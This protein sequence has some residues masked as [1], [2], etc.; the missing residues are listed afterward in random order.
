MIYEAQDY[1][2]ACWLLNDE[3]RHKILETSMDDFE[4]LSLAQQMFKLIREEYL[5]NPKFDI[6][7]IMLSPAGKRY[8]D[9][10]R[11]VT[12]EIPTTQLFP[13]YYERFKK[14]SQQ[15]K[16]K[17]YLAELCLSNSDIDIPEVVQK[18]LEIATGE[19]K[20]NSTGPRE[21]AIEL[22]DMLEE[23]YNL[24]GKLPGI[25]TGYKALD[26]A[27]GGI[28][29]NMYIILGG[30][31]SMGKSAFAINLAFNVL[32]NKGK[33]LYASV[34]MSRK[35]ILARIVA[36]VIKLPLND[37][38]FGVFGDEQWIKIT[39]Q[40]I[41]FLAQSG[42]HILEG[43]T[44]IS[45][46]LNEAKRLKAKY[47]K[48]DL[49]VIDYLQTLR[50]GE[51]KRSEYEKVSEISRALRE[52]AK[53]EHIPV[54]GV[55]QLNRDCEEREN[56][57]PVLSDLKE[58][59]QLE[60]DA[61]VIMFLYRPAYYDEEFEDKTLTELIIAKNRDGQ[62]GTILYSWFEQYQVFVEREDVHR[63]INQVEQG[64]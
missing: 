8:Q 64:K 45:E 1:V 25:S 37:V 34:E 35:Q 18:L 43:E 46:I 32:K 36:R 49:L 4:E 23:A 7:D 63:T 10:I 60:Q 55:A 6:S 47:G 22:Y 53:Q 42:F 52:F 33:V 17:K 54:L 16:V 5:K 50:L 9:Y 28:L 59:S 20:T 62:T 19:D 26:C 44:K 39:K 30:R 38:K 24:K 41:P 3:F 61:D 58:S 2:I 27:I 57:R 56:K 51:T 48:L 12:I 11:D 21:L 14:D 31:P 15:R 40:L 29:D 13:H